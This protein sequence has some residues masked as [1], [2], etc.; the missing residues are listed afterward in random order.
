MATILS[1]ETEEERKEKKSRSTGRRPNL[2]YVQTQIFVGVANC[3]IDYNCVE[4][5]CRLLHSMGYVGISTN[6]TSHSEQMGLNITLKD[7]N[8]YLSGKLSHNI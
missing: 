6:M 2:P 7:L 5:N 4:T 8:A 1:G 3:L